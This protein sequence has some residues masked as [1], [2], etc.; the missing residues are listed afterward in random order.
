MLPNCC[1][2]VPVDAFFWVGWHV[3]VG[4]AEWGWGLVGR[5]KVYVVGMDETKK[6]EQLLCFCC[7]WACLSET[8]NYLYTCI[9]EC[10]DEALQKQMYTIPSH[11]VVYGIC[12]LR[13][14]VRCNT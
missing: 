7:F 13:T 11:D 9:M 4:F 8:E 3:W 12:R 2:R 14:V 6:H 1:G 10:K 5:N